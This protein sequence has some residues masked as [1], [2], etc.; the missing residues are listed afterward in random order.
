MNPEQWLSVP[1]QVELQERL[2]SDG[3]LSKPVC[4]YIDPSS[5]VRQGA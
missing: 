1:Y 5:N 2:Y 3:R 4:G